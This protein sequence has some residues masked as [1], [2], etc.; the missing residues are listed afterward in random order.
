MFLKFLIYVYI[1]GFFQLKYIND[2]NLLKKWKLEEI[3]LDGNE[4]CDKFQENTVY[5]RYW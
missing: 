5:I 4:L 2:L 3:V 1:L